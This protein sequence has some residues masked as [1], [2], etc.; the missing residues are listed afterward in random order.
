MKKGGKE[1]EMKTSKDVIFEKITLQ[2]LREASFKACKGHKKQNQV[3]KFEKNFEENCEMLFERL[4]NGTYKELIEYRQLT[5]VNNNHK[6]RYIDSPSLELRIYQILWLNKIVPLYASKDNGVG[7]NCKE[8]HGITAQERR[9]SVVK[10]MKRLFYDHRDIHYGVVIDQRQCYMHIKEKAYRKMIKSLTTDRKMIDFGCE[11]GFVNNQLPIGTPTSP[12]LHHIIMLCYDIW[13]KENMPFAIRYA[14]DNFIGCYT[15]EDAQQIKWRIKMFWWYKFQIRA[16]KQTAR[17]I[18]LDREKLDFCGYVFNRNE[19]RRKTEHN[20]GYTKLRK[21]TITRAKKSTDRNWGCYYGLLRHAD[22]YGLML[23]I[24][25]D[26]KLR[27]LTQKV[28]IDRQMD[29]KHID[30]KD[31]LGKVFNVYKYEIRYD[32]QKKPNW[33]KCLIGTPEMTEANEPTGKELAFEFHGN[34]QGL[35]TYIKTLEENFGDSFMPMEE[36]EIV[37]EC[38]YIFKGSTNQLKYIEDGIK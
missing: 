27:E 19:G 21:D 13:I 7:R 2:D 30:M 14:D 28:R 4:M 20:K 38:G 32:G 5:K 1:R 8:G 34:Y 17:V 31:V 26:M 16:K 36:C 3:K 22:C 24:E 29:A 35:I 11:I 12:Y 25:K 6:T 18:N 10:E 23:K 33:I 9:Y 15:K 37:N